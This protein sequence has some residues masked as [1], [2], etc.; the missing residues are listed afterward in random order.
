MVR[1]IPTLTSRPPL[2]QYQADAER[3][4]DAYK[5]GNITETE[6]LAHAERAAALLV[7][8]LR[9]HFLVRLRNLEPFRTSRGESFVPKA[10]Q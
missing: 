9:S 2:E 4:L 8:Q 6:A 3:A 10:G 5:L 1:H 7:D